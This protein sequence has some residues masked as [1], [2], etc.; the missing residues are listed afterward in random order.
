MSSSSSSVATYTAS[1]VTTPSFS[2]RK[3]GQ[4][5]TLLEAINTGLLDPQR[6]QY[7]DP[8]SGRAMALSDAAGAGLVDANVVSALTQPT[9]GMRDP[10]TDR[11]ISFLQ[12]IQMGLYDVARAAFVNPSNQEVVSAE[13]AL[14]LGLLIK[15]KVSTLT[16]LGNVR[17]L[18]SFPIHSFRHHPYRRP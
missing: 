3:T 13:E 11:S 10:L 8:V 1:V 6:G 9:L 15:D 12:A 18:M 7:L 4:T 16:A 5:L 17:A 14:H 2:N